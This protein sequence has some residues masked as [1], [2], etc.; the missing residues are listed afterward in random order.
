MSNR[1]R[2]RTTDQKATNNWNNSHVLGKTSRAPK[3]PRLFINVSGESLHSAK[4]GDIKLQNKFPLQAD[5]IKFR[6]SSI[7]SNTW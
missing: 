5:V 4:L 3:C 7:W 6:C 1:T 2:L